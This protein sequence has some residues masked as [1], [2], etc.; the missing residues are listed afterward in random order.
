MVRDVRARWNPLVFEFLSTACQAF[1]TTQFPYART[2]WTWLRTPATS[3]H[4]ARW[5]A[6]DLYHV[7]YD[8]E[9]PSGQA[10][11]RQR[12]IP[13]YISAAEHTKSLEPATKR[14][15]AEDG[16]VVDMDVDAGEEDATK[17][18]SETPASA[19][20]SGSTPVANLFR[21]RSQANIEDVRG[22]I[23]CRLSHSSSSLTRTGTRV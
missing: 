17:T 21:G 5:P 11:H 14:Q 6:L 22:L 23:V 16:T 9:K 4:L 13:C 1:V 12:F 2:I 19:S 15:R 20:T 10:P 8:L 7:L 18:H 3:D